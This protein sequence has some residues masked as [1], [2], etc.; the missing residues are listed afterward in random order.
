VSSLTVPREIVE[1]LVK[2]EPIDEERFCVHCGVYIDWHAKPNRIY[3][4]FDEC[5][6]KQLRNKLEALLSV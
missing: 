3:D 5:P 4:H 1:Q 2:T 6:W